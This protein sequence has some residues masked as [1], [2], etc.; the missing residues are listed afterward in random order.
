VSTMDVVVRHGDREERVRI[1]R[2]DGA[3][4][5]RGTH[6]VTIGERTYTVDAARI[7]AESAGRGRVWSLRLEGQQHEV[8]VRAK[9][10]GVYEVGAAGRSAAVEVLDLLTALAR[11]AGGGKGGRR[12]QRVTAYMPGRVVAVLAAVGEEVTAGRG[13]VVLEAMKM[14]NEILAEQDGVIKAILVQPGQAVEGG[15]PLFE[16]E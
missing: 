13:I 12:R 3:D 6:E 8:S 5:G 2:L 15:D 7:P 11:Q 1:R 10:E 4:P 16:M 9:G 14:Q